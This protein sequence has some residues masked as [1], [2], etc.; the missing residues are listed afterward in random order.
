M[1]ALLAAAGLLLAVL[2]NA[3][4]ATIDVLVTFTPAAQVKMKAQAGTVAKYVD[5]MIENVNRALQTTGS[6]HVLALSTDANGAAGRRL[7]S[8]YAETDLLTDHA[9]LMG[10]GDGFLEQAHS[11]RNSY[12]GDVVLL[13]ADYGEGSFNTGV[14]GS[15]PTRSQSDAFI[16]CDVDRCNQGGEFVFAHEIGHLAGCGHENAATSTKAYQIAGTNII[17]VMWTY[18][19]VGKNRLL[20]YGTNRVLPNFYGMQD[21]RI[22]DSQHDCGGAWIFFGNVMSAYR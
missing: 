18:G 16:A 17:D 1:K 19:Q 6:G 2:P 20:F 8:G 14:A 9:R 10:V 4:A 11:W 21:V 7:F 5:L 3:R 15:Q 13:I 22:G 12:R